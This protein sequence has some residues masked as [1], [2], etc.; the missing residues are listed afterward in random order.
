MLVVGKLSSCFMQINFNSSYFLVDFTL[1]F[2]KL[3]AIAFDMAC[4]LK[5]HT[6]LIKLAQELATPFKLLEGILL[7]LALALVL[8]ITITSLTTLV[9]RF[10]H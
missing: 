7:T 10:N 2:T 5:A 4:L 1:G 3:L 9:F 8:V 6:L